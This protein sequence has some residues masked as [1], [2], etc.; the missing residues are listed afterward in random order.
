M[1]NTDEILLTPILRFLL[2]LLLVVVS[3]S[4]EI[5]S[6]CVRA[7]HDTRVSSYLIIYVAMKKVDTSRPM[8]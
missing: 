7:L 6:V 5:L 3:S 8:E 1:R 2:L 4:I